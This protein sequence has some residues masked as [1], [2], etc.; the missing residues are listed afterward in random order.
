MRSRDQVVWDFVEGWLRMAELDYSVADTLQERRSE[1]AEAVAFHSQQAVEKFIKTLLV[2]HQ[3]EFPKT[4]DIP[5]LRGLLARVDAGLATQ[6]AFADWL[7][8]FGVEVRYPSQTWELPDDVGERALSAA[9]QV[10]ESVMA[11]LDTY[12]RQGRPVS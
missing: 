10:R 7:T 9:R 1:Y 4:H 6:L 5:L 2:R 11:A 8:P 12:L 3:I